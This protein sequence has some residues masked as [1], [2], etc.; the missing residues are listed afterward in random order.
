MRT[1]IVE[2]AVVV[3]NL[4]FFFGDVIVQVRWL[5]SGPSAQSQGLLHLMEVHKPLLFGVMGVM[6]HLTQLL[7]S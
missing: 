7:S 5:Q 4:H 3:P 1:V 6:L 2:L